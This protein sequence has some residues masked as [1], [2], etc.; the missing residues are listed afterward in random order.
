[1]IE[2]GD[3]VRCVSFLGGSGSQL[4]THGEDA[5]YTVVGKYTKNE[6]KFLVVEHTASGQNHSAYEGRFRLVKRNTPTMMDPELELEE[7]HQFQ[8][9]VDGR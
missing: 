4:R 7:I 8:A 6:D 2:I 3:T 9:L 5:L 1:M